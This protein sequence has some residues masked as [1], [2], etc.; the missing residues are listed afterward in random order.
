LGAILS[1]PGGTSGTT[2]TTLAEAAEARRT[3]TPWGARV[4]LPVLGSHFWLLARSDCSW[5]FTAFVIFQSPATAAAQEA[6]VVVAQGSEMA[7]G[8]TVMATAI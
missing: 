4:N 2:A 7:V 1:K 6:E 8:E 5:F 3:T